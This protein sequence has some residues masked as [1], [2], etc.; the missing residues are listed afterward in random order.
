MEH[1]Q[2]HNGYEW[3]TIEVPPRP[4]HVIKPKRWSSQR[5]KL[6]ACDMDKSKYKVVIVSKYFIQ[7]L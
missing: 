2:N 5:S 7:K 3:E 1:N 4:S 6:H